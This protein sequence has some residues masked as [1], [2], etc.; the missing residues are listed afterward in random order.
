MGHAAQKILVCYNSKKKET[1]K[2]KTEKD[3]MIM[4]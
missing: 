3:E 1:L 4:F 2:R